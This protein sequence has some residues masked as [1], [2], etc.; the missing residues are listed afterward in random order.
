MTEKYRP[1][2]EEVK[3]AEHQTALNSDYQRLTIAREMDRAVHGL[4]SLITKIEHGGK[5]N[6]ELTEEEIRREKGPQKPDLK[7]IVDNTKEQSEEE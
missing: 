4:G 6:V 3:A 1:S 2:E 7:L 5:N